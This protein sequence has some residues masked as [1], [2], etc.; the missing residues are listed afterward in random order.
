MPGAVNFDRDLVYSGVTK[1]SIFLG[2]TPVLG[3]AGQLEVHTSGIIHTSFSY[4]NYYDPASADLANSQTLSIGVQFSPLT[5]QNGVFH[6]QGSFGS[7]LDNTFAFPFVAV[8]AA[9]GAQVTLTEFASVGHIDDGNFDVTVAITDDMAG[10][11]VV[12]GLAASA[13]GA[14]A[15]WRPRMHLSVQ[16]IRVAPPEYDAARR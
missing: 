11:T 7:S 15:T 9:P 2:S 12:C 14:A 8:T 5:A 3:S 13:N 10:N 1:D 4:I 6:L 16:N